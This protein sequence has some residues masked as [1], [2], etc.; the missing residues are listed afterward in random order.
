MN[1]RLIAL[2]SSIIF[3][4]IQPLA[5]IAQENPIPP[6][7][8]IGYE[9]VDFYGSDIR[10]ILETTIKICEEACREDA[11]C[12]AITFNTNKDACFLK[13]DVTNHAAFEGALSIEYFDMPRNIVDRGVARADDLSFLPER[14][15]LNA[16]R[17]VQQLARTEPLQTDFANEDAVIS[18]IDYWIE[19]RNDPEEFYWNLKLQSFSHSGEGWL[20]LAHLARA[21]ADKYSSN[22]GTWYGWTADMAI[23]A[24][25]YADTNRDMAEALV[26][27][28]EALEYRR[29]HRETIPALRL[30]Q[31]LHPSRDTAAALDRVIGLYGFRITNHEV[32]NNS[33][34]PEICI[35]FSEDLIDSGVDYNSFV[36]IQTGELPTTAL[37]RRLCIEGVEH[38]RRYSFTVRAGLPA[39]SGEVTHKSVDLEIYVGDR[40]PL[41]R[42]TG[43]AYVLPKSADATIPLVSVNAD[44][45]ELKILRIGDRGLVGALQ[46]GVLNSNL[47]DYAESR[48]ASSTGVE[49][50]T[51]LVDIAPELNSN[52][53]TALPVGDVIDEFEPGIYTMTARVPDQD[54][55]WEDAA[56]QWFIVTD[57]G[58]ETLSGTDG[59]HVFVRGLS[60]AMPRANIKA[61][62][63][64]ANNEILGEV[65]TDADGYANFPVGLISGT[66]GMSPAMVTVAD[67]VE[68]YAFLDLTEAGFDLSDRGVEGSKSPGPIDVFLTTERGAYRPYET[69]HATILARDDRANALSTLPLTAIVRRPDG[70]EFS[71]ELL[72]G[73]NEGGYAYD[74]YLPAS[75][76][77]GTWDIQVY[78]DVDEAPLRR[79]NFLVEDFVPERIDFEIEMEDRAFSLSENP[80][81][82]IAANYLYGAPAGDLTIEGEVQVTQARGFAAY[83]N[84][85][86]GLADEEFTEGY[87]G[88]DPEVTDANGEV[89]FAL[90]FPSL[91][92]GTR[93]MEMRA[94][95][96]MADGSGRP[97][98][99]SVTRQIAPASQLIGIKPLFDNLDGSSLA[100][101]EVITIG[102]DGERAKLP[103]VAWT[104]SKINRRYQWYR[105]DGRWRWESISKRTRID[106]GEIALTADALGKIEGMVE[107]GRYELKLV[108]LDSDYAAASYTFSA[109]WWWSDGGAG[110]DTPD[111]LQVGLDQGQYAVGD[112][113][114]LRLD[115]RYDGVVLVRVMSNRLIDMQ[116][117][118][119]TAGESSVD[120]IV[121]D[122]WGSG[123]YVTATLI[124]PMDTETGQN[125]SRAIGLAYAPIDPG[126]R[127]LQASFDMPSEATPRQ[128]MD[129]ALKIDGGVPGQTVYATIAAVDLGILNLTG[130]DSPDPSEH[131]FGQH[132]LGM[133][134]HDIYGRLID[135]SLG[136]R[137]ALR[138]GGDNA[139]ARASAPPPTQELLAQFSGMLTMG[140]D[141]YV[142]TSFDMPEFNGTVRL[143]AV[144]WS[145]KGVGQAEQDI[146]VRD[147]IVLTTAMPRFMAPNDD[148]RILIE[149]AHATGPTGE[150]K[151]EVAVQ[152]TLD[153]ASR[154]TEFTFDMGDL[155][156]EVISIPIHATQI[157]R[158]EIE[159]LL[160]TPD[161]QELAKHLTL[162]IRN[163]TPPT[164]RQHKVPLNP[165]G[166]T[167]EV[168]ADVFADYEPGSATAIL[169]MGTL[170]SVDAPAL[171]MQLDRYPYGC[172]EQIT[173]KAMPLLYYGEVAEALEIEAR[174]MTER[175]NEAITTLLTRQSGSGGFGLWRVGRDSMWLDA[176]VTDF[177]SRA[178]ALGYDVP[179]L[180]FER[181]LDNLN[182]ELNYA[183]DFENGGQDVAYALMV[184][185]REGRA[186]I[187][188]LRYYADVKRHDFATPMALAQLA[189]GL[190]YYGDQQRADS[191]FVTA[192]EKTNE[193]WDAREDRGWRYDYGSNYRDTAAV[194]ALASEVRSNAIDRASLS[195]RIAYRSSRWLSTQDATWSLLAVHSAFEN[196]ETGSVSIDGVP[197]ASTP[198]RRIS[199][200]DLAYSSMIVQNSGGFEIDGVLTTIGI[201]STP[202]PATSNGYRIDRALYT[203]EGEEVDPNNV[204]QNARLVVVLK[205]TPE[206]ERGGRLMVS[207]PLPAGFEIDN[208]HL[209][210]AGD[211]SA[212]DW[213]D[214]DESANHS[215]FREDRFL[216]AVDWHSRSSFQMAYIVRAISPGEFLQPA[217]SIE[218]MYRPDIRAR[219]TQGRITIVAE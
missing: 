116:A 60:D 150:V 183:S 130:F 6:Q 23:N 80:T 36:R 178:R 84:Y 194:I 158:G 166:G 159:I 172:S 145:D 2:L 114:K 12:S 27:L 77:R 64:A 146:L 3:L 89:S 118:E 67:G 140:E 103:R 62:L 165:N 155:E 171:L 117:V 177:L 5:L 203:L 109:G 213:L 90:N 188:D 169:T 37:G 10:T 161:G 96:R 208:P 201:P 112:T 181:A 45:A 40:D 33:A 34:H 102:E 173:S 167:F 216:A 11:Q 59:L 85:A 50:W 219:T 28:A 38:G 138:S 15:I 72:I 57:L 29:V 144:V 31:A 22:R 19:R 210:R 148:S 95:M 74:V 214:L 174:D 115:A 186:S 71:R 56:T 51:G 154:V 68:D 83:P 25:L 78:A 42:F 182:N 142:R 47:D 124:R 192:Q 7:R 82:S 58:L 14:Y 207:D 76:Q 151:V 122:D 164:S 132:R 110:T 16:T 94:T 13:S 44:I 81:V 176:Y 21:M 53:I 123:A 199:E 189:A 99:R 185:A 175:V 163:N 195:R 170:A 101:F 73:S 198:V 134:I 128:T 137:G 97:V 54:E 193:I 70:V 152:G 162:D 129:V 147:P 205:V 149:L 79:Q 88:I 215:E 157:G 52:V 1:R 127:A 218:D 217:A 91:N 200:A 66:G 139:L 104:L 43:S 180:A 35:T 121:T 197:I 49:V 143:M 202:M 17:R 24:Y 9:N 156:R 120:L 190:A 98:E 126:P 48:I 75:S 153:V 141:G 63:V 212:L 107:W 26:L 191:L 113:A 131:Y 179:D 41:V 168:S 55:G 20:N 100:R 106:S 135:G 211:I 93:P 111:L 204:P 136:A 32:N 125:P 119:V 30:A 184:L 46:N 8:G 133:E 206:R 196:A 105:L 61:T 87:K 187:G 86:F 209:L 108:A 160:T 39:A 65:L 92:A 18:G 4:I 69:V